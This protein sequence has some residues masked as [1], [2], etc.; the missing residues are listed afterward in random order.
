MTL[1]GRIIL[2]AGDA[3]AIV[4]FVVIGLLT[5]G[6]GID[7]RGLLRTAAPILILWF[8]IAPMIGTYRRPGWR[9][10]LPTWAIAVMGGLLVRRVIFHRPSSWG[11]LLEFMAVSLAFTLL[12][13]SAWRLVARW[14]GLIMFLP[15]A[16]AG[17]A[18]R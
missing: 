5:H 3:A 15:S 10:M 14:T 13:L 8:A 9:T 17:G 16:A 7:P 18:R 4:A 6:E 11:D 1:R 12:F 2:A